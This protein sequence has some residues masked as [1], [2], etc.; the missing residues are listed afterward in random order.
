MCP[1]DSKSPLIQVMDNFVSHSHYVFFF[2][3]LENVDSVTVS[4]GYR[5][6]NLLYNQQ[7]RNINKYSCHYIYLIPTFDNNEINC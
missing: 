6:V 2:F 4:M 1:T 7:R 3:F 5:Q